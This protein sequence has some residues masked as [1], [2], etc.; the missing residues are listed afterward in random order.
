M[1][2]LKRSR[3]ASTWKAAHRNETCLRSFSHWRSRASFSLD[4]RHG[5]DG[6]FDR[7]ARIHDRYAV[8][9]FG[10][11]D[12]VV[13]DLRTGN[14]FRVDRRAAIACAALANSDFESSV[15]EV[16][17]R[18]QVPHSHASRIVADTRAALD[19]APTKGTPTGPYHYYPEQG[20]FGLWHEGKRVLAV[21]GTNL[22]IEVAPG[23]GIE[24]SPLLEFYVRGLARK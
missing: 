13:I 23:L 8:E 14:Y 22:E 15:D 11:G 21:K 3:R 19:A 24:K 16:A 9:V 6:P 1:R 17:R 20:G 4:L 18:L 10:S 2:Q 7:H 5:L 12:G